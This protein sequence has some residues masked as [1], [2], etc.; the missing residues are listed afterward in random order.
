[1]QEQK[2]IVVIGGGTGTFTVLKGLKHYDDLDL[3]AIVTMTDDGGSTGRLRDEFGTLPVGD[4]RQCLVALAREDEAGEMLRS[5]FLYRFPSS[6]SSLAGHNFG[7]LFLTALTDI[8]GSE[9]AAIDAAAEILNV[10]GDILPITTDQVKLAA[11]YDN[12]DVLVGEEY[13]DEPDEATH[14]CTARVVKLW[15]QPKAQ[16]SEEARK[17]IETADEIIIGPGDLYSSLLSNVVIEG[18]PE[19]I[20]KS[21]GKFIY[22]SNLVSK[23]GQTHGMKLSDYIS[24]IENYSGRELDKAVVNNSELPEAILERYENENSYPILDDGP[25]NGKIIRGDVVSSQ[26]VIRKD[27]DVVKRSL[28]RH[29]SDKLAAQLVKLI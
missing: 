3:T 14:D 2:K 24:E 10:N 22:V 7:N 16:I 1:M 21:Q 23:Y 5:L 12:G 8:L 19:A 28:L 18:V 25:P 6:D 20:Q 26:E 4:V 11:Q 15:T 9:V 27:G 17:A 13:V 29:D